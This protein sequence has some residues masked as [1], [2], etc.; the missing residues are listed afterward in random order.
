[1]KTMD[2]TKR[3]N[4]A[5]TM[6][7]TKRKSSGCRERRFYL[8]VASYGGHHDHEHEHEEPKGESLLDKIAEKIHAHDSSSSDFDDNKGNTSASIKPKGLVNQIE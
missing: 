5:R 3:N 7:P 2:P 1:M 4:Q 6:D 8:V